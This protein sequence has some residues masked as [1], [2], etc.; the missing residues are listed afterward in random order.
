MS[1]SGEI[2]FFLGPGMLY[3]LDIF[4]LDIFL[5]NQSLGLRWFEVTCPN[6]RGQGRG[7]METGVY[8]RGLRLRGRWDILG[9][10]L[11]EPCS[12]GYV[13]K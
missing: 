6:R 10:F 8:E 13:H 12:H 5:C 2:K 4:T 9:W 3:L 7:G 1:K 11:K